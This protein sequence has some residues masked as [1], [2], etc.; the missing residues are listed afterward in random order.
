MRTQP[1]SLSPRIAIPYIFVYLAFGAALLACTENQNTDCKDCPASTD[2]TGTGNPDAD[3]DTDTDTD[4]DGD[5]D[6]DTDT[7]SDTDADTGGYD[8]RTPVIP[9]VDDNGG[10][11]NVTTYGNVTDPQPS[12]GGACNF[13]VTEIYNFAAINVNVEPGDGLG[14]WNGGRICGQ[15]A[16]VTAQT[17]DGDKSTVV[18]IVDKC[19]DGFCGIDLGGLPA[20]TLMGTQPGRYD[21]TWEFV[22]C[23][24][25][26]GVSDGVPSLY[27]KDGSNPWWAL[28]QVRNPPAAVLSILW[29]A[30]A[31]SSGEFSFA[32]EAE[33][34]YTVPTEVRE[35]TETIALTIQFD[36]DITL[37][38]DI[39]GT[40]LTLENA[41]YAL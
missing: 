21:G 20:Q 26:E 7:D 2:T 15:C 36:F 3:T 29:Q 25:Y 34:F 11:G 17:A 35:S 18:R 37:T 5:V 30:P 32:T 22:P 6:A 9:T 31:G 40:A 24:G 28:V 10:T 27:V 33:N 19:P 13:G 39:V 23:D 14:H 1:I 8:S 4:A 41:L 16:R 12:S 38:L